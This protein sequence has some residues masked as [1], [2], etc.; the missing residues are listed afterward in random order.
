[1]PARAPHLLAL[2][3]KLSRVMI[4]RHQIYSWQVRRQQLLLQGSPGRFQQQ[5]MPAQHYMMQLAPQ[6]SYLIRVAA[7]SI[8][9]PRKLLTRLMLHSMERC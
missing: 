9:L 2:G 7:V 5:Q 4:S 6:A 1:M 3:L 8:Q